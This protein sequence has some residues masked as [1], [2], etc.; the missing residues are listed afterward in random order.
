[1]VTA[2]P[3]EIVLDSK[4]YKLQD[5]RRWQKQPV[6]RAARKIGG[7]DTKYSDYDLWNVKAW[8]TWHLGRGEEYFET[9][10]RYHDSWNAET[11]VRGQITLGPHIYATGP[12]EMMN[13]ES[14]TLTPAA[15]GNTVYAWTESFVAPTGD[16]TA[17]SALLYL[18]KSGTP[19]DDI[20]VGIYTDSSGPNTLVTGAEKTLT[21]ASVGTVYDWVEFDWTGTVTLTGGSTYWIVVD[22]DTLSG[23]S[24]NQYLMGY[25]GGAGYAGAFKYTT[26]SDWASWSDYS[27]SGDL[28][29]RLEGTEG[30]LD[31]IPVRFA[32]HDGPGAEMVTDGAM[33]DW[34]TDDLD[35]WSESDCDAA[36]ETS[37]PYGGSGSSAKVTASDSNG[38]IYQQIGVTAGEEYRLQFAYK[39]TSGDTAS[40]AVYDVSNSG[41]ILAQTDLPSL[42]SWSDLI[43]YEFAAPT[44]CSS[45]YIKFFAKANT[46]IVWFD[47]VTLKHLSENLL[48]LA[49]A[50]VYYWDS[51]NEKWVDDSAGL[52]GD[53][54]NML[55]VGDSLYVAQGANG[56]IRVKNEETWADDVDNLEGDVLGMG[57]VPTGDH[58]GKYVLIRGNAVAGHEHRAQY[59]YGGDWYSLKGTVDEQTD[60]GDV[61]SAITWIGVYQGSNW[62]GKTDGVYEVGKDG[63]A[64]N[65]FPFFTQKAS[66]NFR[67]TSV[68]HRNELILPVAYGVWSFDG[69]TLKN[70]GPGIAIAGPY[71]FAEAGAHVG[72]PT[73][74]QGTVYDTLPAVN[75]LYACIDGSVSGAYSSVMLWTGRG[76]H[77]VVRGQVAAKAIRALGYTPAGT[78][79][80]ESRL[81]Y[82]YDKKVFYAILPDTT[83]DPYQWA[84]SKYENTG[85]I[86]FAWFNAGLFEVDKDW[87]DVTIEAENVSAGQRIE[88]TYL[89]D[90]DTTATSL[91]VIDD[92]TLGTAISNNQATLSFGTDTYGK[93][94]KL[95]IYLA[96]EDPDETPKITNVKLKYWKVPNPV[97]GW[98]F[99]LKLTDLDR[100]WR[101]QQTD[102]ETTFE[103]KEPVT[104]VDPYGASHTV[105]LDNLAET[106]IATDTG[107]PLGCLVTVRAVEA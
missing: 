22:T 57:I 55:V 27:S 83:D 42:T 33:D 24:S 77:E 67:G 23:S 71:H 89:L 94:I 92:G 86:D 63:I 100:S 12:G 6:L 76:W 85:G 104:L 80:D 93:R 59:L 73:D 69:R 25:D 103:K 60:V 107:E 29:F 34:T 39:N 37:S 70:I 31:G 56:P 96:T 17:D 102:F 44:G 47:A 54:T 58:A 74:R 38:F 11:R 82:G 101:T 81:W 48:V 8:N 72:L 5:P 53:G 51:A 4:R 20:T 21:E 41:D 50:Y 45:I 1:M 88:V 36:E 10:G 52:S 30:E 7:G 62:L 14:G 91:G 95:S 43:E 90:D 18:R 78:I 26:A 61:T 2:R 49:G 79:E 97:Y 40:Y 84:S 64:Y 16:L 66:W 87:R 19:A 15:L 35:S 98:N 65:K 105:K 46:D 13:Y 32:F 75:A 106:I 9:D 3:G 99:T 28:W 68:W